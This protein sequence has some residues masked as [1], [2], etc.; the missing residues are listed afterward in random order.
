MKSAPLN[1]RASA[2]GVEWLMEDLRG[3]EVVLRYRELSPSGAAGGESGV[4]GQRETG[5]HQ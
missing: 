3:P 1:R 2:S 5:P 4:D